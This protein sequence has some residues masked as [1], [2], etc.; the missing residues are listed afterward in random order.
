M[1]IFLSDFDGTLVNED[2]LDIV[3]EITGHKEESK[4]LNEEIIW[5]ENRSW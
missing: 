1:R 4:K 3:C 5:K 2:I